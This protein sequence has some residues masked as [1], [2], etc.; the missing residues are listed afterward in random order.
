MQTLTLP[1]KMNLQI[2]RRIQSWCENIFEFE[3]E[4]LEGL[5]EG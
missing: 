1:R 2:N 4:T 3:S 5:I